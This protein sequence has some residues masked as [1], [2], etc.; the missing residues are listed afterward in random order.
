MWIEREKIVR[1]LASPLAAALVLIAVA[2]PLA[3]QEAADATPRIAVIDVGRILEESEAG[4]DLLDE[5]EALATAK[6]EEGKP[7]AEKTKQLQEQL[8]SGSLSLSQEKL[9]ELQTEFQNS[10]KAL[11]RFEDDANEEIDQ[12]RKRRLA[13]IE[14]RVLRVVNEVGEEFGYTMMFNKFQSGLVYARPE[15][16]I[17]DTILERF[18]AATAAEATSGQ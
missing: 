1:A 10:A 3:A 8:Q 14:R 7:L 5:I 15:L 9:A 11:K 6:G 17:T 12:L 18:N 16:D 2:A 13:A 4:K